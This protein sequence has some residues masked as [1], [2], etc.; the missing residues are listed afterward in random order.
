MS[1]NSASQKTRPVKE[2]LRDISLSSSPLLGSEIYHDVVPFIN[3]DAVANPD[4]ES[5]IREIRWEMILKGRHSFLERAV[6]LG[7]L[8]LLNSFRG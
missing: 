2:I 5:K 4:Q 1:H 3:T 6:Y 7:T 8:T